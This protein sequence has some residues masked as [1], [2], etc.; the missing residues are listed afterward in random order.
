MTSGIQKAERT[1]S[2]N[3]SIELADQISSNVDRYTHCILQTVSSS[4]P[5]KHTVLLSTMSLEFRVRAFFRNIIFDRKFGLIGVFRRI[6][7]DWCSRYNPKVS[8]AEGIFWLSVVTKPKI[9]RITNWRM[10]YR[11]VDAKLTLRGVW[12]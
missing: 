3:E 10:R 4:R 8:A 1:F 12:V 9:W 6:L 7:V 2:V 5:M 11:R